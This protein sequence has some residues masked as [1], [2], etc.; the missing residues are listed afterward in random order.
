MY[1]VIAVRMDTFIPSNTIVESFSFDTQEKA[2][3]F[4]VALSDE[5]RAEFTFY[6][7]KP[8]PS[9]TVDQAVQSLLTLAAER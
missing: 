5:I 7:Q 4:A 2:D 1:V 8:E 9:V 6:S 3:A